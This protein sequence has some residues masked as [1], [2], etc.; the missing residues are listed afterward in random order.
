MHGARRTCISRPRRAGR[1]FVG[2]LVVVHI[3]GISRTSASQRW[4]Q[5]M[6]LVAEWVF[7]NVV[8][9]CEVHPILL[10]THSP[11]HGVLTKL[12]THVRRVAPQ[13]DR[14]YYVSQVDK[15]IT[16]SRDGSF[17]CVGS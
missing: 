15:Y 8:R 2:P 10:A 5:G 9:Y 17:R 3:H 7:A 4:Q 1:T 6:W 14:V 16:C 13:V 12:F 11:G